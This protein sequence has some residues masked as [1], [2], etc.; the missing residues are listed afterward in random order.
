MKS[1]FAIFVI[2][3]L[4]ATVL[5]PLLRRLCQRWGLVDESRDSRRVHVTPTP[6]LGGI[7]IFASVV[8]ALSGLL[9]IHNN[10]TAA[11]HADIR[12][13]IA[14]LVCA[15]LVLLIGVYDDTRGANAVVK[16]ISLGA[17]AVLF[18]ALGGRIQSVAIPFVGPVGLPAVIGLSVTLIWL[19]GITNAFNLIDGVDGLAAG[20]ALFSS[21][22]IIVISLMQS[23]SYATVVALALAG[24]LAGFLRYNFNPASI[25][26][27]D[28]GALLIGFSLAALSIQGSQ[29][30]TTAVALAI[31]ILAFGLPV[32]DTAVTIARRLLSGKPIFSGDREHIHHM[33]LA[34]GWS[35]RRVAVVLYGVSAAFGLLAMLFVGAKNP[36]MSVVLFVVGIV[37]VTAVGHLRYHEVDEL[38]ASVKRNIGERRVRAANNIRVRRASRALANATTVGQL[39]DGLLEMLEFDQ[40]VYAT[41]QLSQ[42]D[43]AEI[44]ARAFDLSKSAAS[45]RGAEFRE[46]RI[47]WSWQRDGLSAAD[48][49]GSDQY[50]ALRLPLS[51]NGTAV[52]YMNLYR[53]LNGEPMRLD[54]NYLC[55]MFRPQ[56]A[57]SAVRVFASVSRDSAKHFLAGVGSAR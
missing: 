41:V 18:Y 15:T 37:V 17:V 26:L 40:F 24:A 48:I 6:R 42:P 12:K 47:H 19:V 10:L 33:L 3:V 35:Q 20:S 8:I 7:A 29:K 9:L 43:G 53:A 16:F 1:Y 51:T 52:G 57:E 36:V 11:L 45:M 22:V 30:S 49:V 31:P 50:W 23:N 14:F 39:F 46:G 55:D 27:G 34:R 2:A 4:S 5:T 44:C 32:V 13:M 25:F 28:S 38:K 21:L 56:L 54:I